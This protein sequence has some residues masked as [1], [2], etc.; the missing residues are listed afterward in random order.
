MTDG[1]AGSAISITEFDYTGIYDGASHTFT[2]GARTKDPDDKVVL[3][4]DD[5]ELNNGNYSKKGSI[6]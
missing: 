4:F 3:Y 5:E 6:E 1:E 2:I